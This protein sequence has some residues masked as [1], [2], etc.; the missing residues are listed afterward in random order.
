MVKRVYNKPEINFESFM[1]SDSVASSVGS[2]CSTTGNYTQDTCGIT[3][4]PGRAVYT[5]ANTGCTVKIEDGAD[6]YPC[7][8]LPT[9]DNNVFGSF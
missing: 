2:S 9:T 8:G 7:M 1:V 4:A 6:G 5:E 3:I